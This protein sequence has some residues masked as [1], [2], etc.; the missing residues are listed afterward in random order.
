[1]LLNKNYNSK[2]VM[3][4]SILNILSFYI[5]YKM[6][7]YIVNNT[8][9]Y[10]LLIVKD[11]V[12]INLIVGFISIF[13]FF[14]Y[15]Y[16]YNDDYFHMFSLIY[17]S[18]YFEFVYMTFLGSKL[19]IFDL[20]ETNEIF[21]GIASLF[22]TAIIW[23]AFY[24]DNKINKYL[25]KNKILAIFLSVCITFVCITLELYLMNNNRLNHHIGAIKFIKYSGNII[26]FI[27]LIKF[28]NSYISKKNIN[29]FI[30]FLGAEVMFLARIL[31][32]SDLYS[33]KS[34][35][36]I[37]NRI[38]L[39]VGFSII[40]I[41]MFWEII[42]KTKENRKLIKQCSSQQLEMDKLKQE[43]ELRT[44][45]FANISHELRTPLNIL[46]CSFQL[47]NSKSHNKDDLYDY[48]H[49]YSNIITTNSSRMLRL[50]NNII[51]ASKFES[52]C[53]KMNFRNINII[54]LIEDITLSIAQCGKIQNRNVIFDTNTEYLEIKCD[55]DSIE[56]VILNL[57]SNAIK[58]TDSD[59]NIYVLCEES[60]AELIIK[61]KDDG[62]G[63]PKEFR[64]RI[65]ERFVQVDKSFRRNVE[66]SGIGLSLV[67][68]IVDSHS[69]QVYLNDEVEKGCEFIIKIP[70][71]LMDEDNCTS[72]TQCLKKEIESK[73]YMELSDI[74]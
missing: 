7:I 13:S 48:Y 69:G 54:S 45:F 37:L 44:Q 59:G 46:I 73:V 63:I 66:G 62:I 14:L 53:F 71:L 40:V 9:F 28:C 65:F 3:Y 51:D 34:Y 49:K 15:S 4:V 67:K 70:K 39:A 50:I 10:E 6:T 26:T 47:L 56:R 11:I 32:S 29:Y 61:V 31:I 2:Q 41:S 27:I 36:Y 52:G 57:L 74:R 60:D 1:M 23:L 38:L 20:M 64:E 68:F 12:G 25:Q 35:M 5:F 58:F 24:E 72:Y 17:I 42:S 8:R 30:T 16:L 21:I 43:D 33:D 19:S 18:L 55:P 22:R